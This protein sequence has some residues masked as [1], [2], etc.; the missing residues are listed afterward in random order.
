MSC[1]GFDSLVN[2]AMVGWP[3]RVHPFSPSGGLLKGRRIPSG[4]LGFLGAFHCAIL[5][6]YVCQICKV[7][8]AVPI[9]GIK[10]PLV[11]TVVAKG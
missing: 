3:I 10:D 2:E 6:Y 7:Q 4:C 11:H 1:E 9:E 8:Y 5:M